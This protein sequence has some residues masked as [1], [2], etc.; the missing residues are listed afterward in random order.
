MQFRT[1]IPITPSDFPIDYHSKVVLLGSCFAENIGSKF[2]YYKFQATIN[3]FGIIFNAV[4]LEKLV[5][6]VVEKNYFT[7]KDIF[8]H[9]D[10]WHCYEVHS[11]LSNVNKEEFLEKLNQLIELT[12]E[13]INKLTHCLITLGTSWVYRHKTSNEIV[14]NCHKVPQKEFTKEL[15][16]A[17]QNQL[18]LQNIVSLIQSINPDVKF[19]FTVSP[20]RH[21]KDGFFENNVSKANLFSAIHTLLSSRAESRDKIQNETLQVL[22]SIR[23]ESSINYFPSYEI[24]MDELRDYRFFE[25][26]MLHPNALAID[27]IWE[28]FS[29]SYFNSE[30]SSIMKEVEIIQKGLAHRPFNP[31]T[32]AH[33][34]FLTDLQKKIDKLVSN[35]PSI[36]F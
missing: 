11:E 6:R 13:Q 28:K 33:Q 27:Y 15:L 30:T 17:A 8:F 31:N 16:S 21:I 7:E 18:S 2:E 9:N 34:K 29:Q 25:A 22:N 35:N 19:V 4:S 12:N 3:P 10:L 5:K 20:V 1:E 24:V 26:D 32:E 36:L 23:T 14:A